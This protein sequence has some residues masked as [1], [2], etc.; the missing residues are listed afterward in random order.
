MDLKLGLFASALV[1][2]LS[3]GP[4]TAA[5]IEDD[6]ELNDAMRLSFVIEEI[7]QK[8]STVEADMNKLQK[9]FTG[10][11]KHAV[12]QGYDAAEIQSALGSKPAMERHMSAARAYL[13]VQGVD[14]G[15]EASVCAFAAN[16]MKSKSEIGK[17]L[18]TR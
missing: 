17:L 2:A 18:K 6:V 9:H 8:C 10:V 1:L 7:K 14:L 3:I 12:K 5:G 11:A 15:N 4:V 16:E 13:A